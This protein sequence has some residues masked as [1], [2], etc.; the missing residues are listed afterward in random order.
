MAG[1][2]KVTLKDEKILERWGVVIERAQGNTVQLYRDA[3]GFIKASEAPGVAVEVV[4]AKPERGL[5]VKMMKGS[6]DRDY[7]LVTNEGLKD[8]RMYIGAR[9][10]GVYLDVQWYL[11][12]EPGFFSRT[13][14]KAVSQG[15]SDNAV[16]FALDLFEQ[17]DLA[18]YTTVVHRCLLKAV[19]KLMGTLGQD[20]STIDRKSKGFL[21]V[22]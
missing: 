14:S 3:Q 22:S 8:Y 5:I 4:T 9:D 18:A 10:Y 1:E 2:R 11:S 7:L 16:S 20:S 12:C 15:A 13:L 19:D 21:G 17:Q 6:G